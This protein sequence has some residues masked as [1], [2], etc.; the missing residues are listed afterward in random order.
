ME[1]PDPIRELERRTAAGEIAP[2]AMPDG[3]SV[4]FRAFHDFPFFG[5]DARAAAAARRQLRLR[6]R[7]GVGDRP[8]FPL[9]PDFRARC[10]QYDSRGE[11]GGLGTLLPDDAL[12]SLLAADF[13]RTIGAGRATS[14]A[15]TER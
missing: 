6:R 12:A 5:A 11:A 9:L 7:L 4:W 15:K 1:T 8:D 13:L 3:R 14:Y 10:V 2:L